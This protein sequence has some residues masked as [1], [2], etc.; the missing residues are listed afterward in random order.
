MPFKSKEHQSQWQ[1]DH[2]ENVRRNSAAFRVRVRAR[3]IA[4]YGGRCVNCCESDP[5]VLVLDHI[6]DD[7]QQDRKTN[8]HTGGCKMYRQLEL[9]GWP[10]AGY[11]LMCHNCNFRKEYFRR[12]RINLKEGLFALDQ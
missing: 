8:G 1:K 5:V 11:Q 9:K 10:K 7:A 12:R 3:M 6:N 2:P 4:A